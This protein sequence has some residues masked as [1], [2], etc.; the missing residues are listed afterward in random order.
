MSAEKGKAWSGPYFF[1]QA[2]D[3]QLGLIQ[4]YL[5]KN[6]TP[7]WQK[8]IALTKLAVEKINRMLQK[9]K[10]FVICGDLCDAFPSKSSDFFF[11]ETP[12]YNAKLRY[13]QL[14]NWFNF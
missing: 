2:A 7:G 9:P 11:A 3:C 6:P 13:L 12:I 14:T 1:I 10:F 4:R 5:E 8:E